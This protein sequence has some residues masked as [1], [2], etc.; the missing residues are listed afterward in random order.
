MKK[1]T[2]SFM[3]S[4]MT[5]ESL[6]W[7]KLNMLIMK[8]FSCRPWMTCFSE[9]VFFC[10]KNE[11]AEIFERDRD[12]R[13]ENIISWYPLQNCSSSLS[14]YLADWKREIIWRSLCQIWWV[15]GQPL[16]LFEEKS[17][18]G[19]GAEAKHSKLKGRWKSLCWYVGGFR[20]C[21]TSDKGSIIIKGEEG[22]N[23]DHYYL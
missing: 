2:K 6:L 10:T 11:L 23:H 20:W 14:E 22:E 16:W 18:R 5:L 7:Q 1:T 17:A 13:E 12:T 3:Y 21:R 4:R 8:T 9:N 19:A 15:S